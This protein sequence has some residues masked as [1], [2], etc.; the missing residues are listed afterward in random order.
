MKNLGRFI[1]IILPIVL[2]VFMLSACSSNTEPNNQ[3][4]S[5]S[6]IMPYQLPEITLSRVALLDKIKGLIIGAAI[7]DAMGAPTEMWSRYDIKMNYGHVTDLQDM[8]RLP[9]G[10]GTWKNNLPAG[11]T[12]DDT[13]WKSM[14]GE[15]LLSQHKGLYKE[16]GPDPKTLASFIVGR[17]ES[18]ISQLKQ[19]D[20][21][22]PLPFEDQARK[23][24][25]L[26]EWAI[27]A[28]PLVEGKDDLYQ[29]AL[30][31]F[32]GGEMT[33]AGMLYSP[34][35]GM[36]YPGHPEKAYEAAYNLAIFD[37]GY[38]R[39][40][41]ALVAA[42]VAA[43]FEE[44]IEGDSVLKV[45]RNVDPYHYFNS[46][47]VSRPAYR[48]YREAKWMVYESKTREE[49]LLEVK[50]VIPKNFPDQDTIA[51]ARI[52]L[53]YGMLDDKNQDMPFHPA[54]IFRVCIASMMYYDFDFVRSLELAINFGRD[55]DTSGALIGAIL[56]AYVGFSQLPEKMV[57]QVLEV[58][59]EQLETDLEDLAEQL[60][61]MIKP[62][63]NS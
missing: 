41:T 59:R 60:V 54:E 14:M 6:K 63:E 22:D 38:A 36:M 44:N 51:Y 31:K 7:G 4:E 58:N 32:Y 56:G 12:T 16:G 2:A 61:N 21:F 23:M 18:Q 26:Q 1:L 52:Q 35:I 47:L 11:G 24:A 9:S 10:E 29:R 50:G 20:S 43:S 5:I 27:V 45:V 13:R 39:D 33:C 57:S 25:W 48:F 53:L 37:I 42:M 3:K 28:K 19:T 49:E 46:R 40:L 34:M 8:V 30:H 62:Q 17:Y 55:N 15:Y